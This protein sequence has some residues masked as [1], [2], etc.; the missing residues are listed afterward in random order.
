LKLLL[1]QEPPEHYKLQVGIIRDM[2]KN[3]N[4]IL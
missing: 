2:I 3:S 1:L 4:N